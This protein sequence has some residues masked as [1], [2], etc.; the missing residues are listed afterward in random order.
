MVWKPVRA[1]FPFVL[2]LIGV[3]TVQ[4][5]L[6]A[7]Y[8]VPSA[9]MEPSL[10]IGDQLGTINFTYGFSTA[11][12]PFGNRLPHSG[13]MAKRLLGHAPSR[14]DVVVFRSPSL[15]STTWVKRVIALPGD[16]VAL[17]H[18]RVTING[19][20]LPW[21]DKGPAQEILAD[22]RSVP[23]ERFAETLPG[24]VVHDILKIE[25]DGP[26]DNIAAFTVPADRLFVMGDNRDDSADSRV[27]AAQGGV[28]LLP[29]WN[30]EG[31][32]VSV[33]WSWDHFKLRSERFFKAV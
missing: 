8:E 3:V 22:R 5:A 25:E 26:L 24:G 16:Q 15:P 21:Q 19:Q 27:P 6:A 14:G 1:A 23:A 11:Q 13:L 30:L 29:F 7:R 28:G 4:S 10:M 9:S 18:G 31:K 32:V 33:L 20:V 17:N 12:L 2:T